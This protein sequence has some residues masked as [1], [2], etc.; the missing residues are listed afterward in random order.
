MCQ[1]G[2]EGAVCERISCHFTA[3]LGNAQGPGSATLHTKGTK[4]AC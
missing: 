1:A 2:Y 3:S 4:A